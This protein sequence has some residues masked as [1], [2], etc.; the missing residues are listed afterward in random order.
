VFLSHAGD[1]IWVAE[2]IATHIEACGATAFLDRRDISAGDNFKQR[3]HHE[4]DKCDELLALFTPWSRRRAWVRH[5]IGMADMLRKRIVCVFYKVTIEDFKADE[6]GLGP[7]D[8]LSTIELNNL[9]T[10]LSALRR[11]VG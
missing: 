11:R 6:D 7:L 4:I 2:Q 9:G 10:Y 3:L 5:E 8:G 1:D